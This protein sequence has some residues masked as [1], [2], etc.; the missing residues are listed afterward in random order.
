VTSQLKAKGMTQDETDPDVLVTYHTGTKETINVNSYGYSYG[1]YFGGYGVGYRDTDVMQVTW[2]NL[3]IDIVDAEQK[4]LVWRGTA[5]K[6]IDENPTPEQID[7][8]INEA[9]AK[10]LEQYPPQ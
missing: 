2:G 7:R 6:A 3:F 4:Q 10:I 8:T 9:V 1:N 5:Q